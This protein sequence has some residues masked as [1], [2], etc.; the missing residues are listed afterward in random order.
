MTSFEIENMIAIEQHKDLL[1]EVENA[2]LVKIALEGQK[3]FQFERKQRG[4]RYVSQTILL[5][6]GR[7]LSWIGSRIQSWGCQLQVHYTI[8]TVSG[9][10]RSG[11][12]S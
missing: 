11:E 10:S 6:F 1:R 8:S 2:R 9:G 7:T 12:C 3:Q 5:L 4:Y